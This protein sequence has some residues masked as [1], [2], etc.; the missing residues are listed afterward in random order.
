MNFL[1]FLLLAFLWGIPVL[2]AR[3]ER[4]KA[5]DEQVRELIR[6][7]DAEAF[8]DREKAERALIAIGLAANDLIQDTL[9]NGSPEQQLRAGR[10]AAAFE[11]LMLAGGFHDLSGPVITAENAGR[12]RFGGELDE[13]VRRIV[14]SPDH[15]RVAFVGRDVPVGIRDGM[16]LRNVEDFKTKRGPMSFAFSPRPGVVAYCENGGLPTIHQLE[17]GQ[18]RK[19]ETDGGQHKFSFSPDGS[20]LVTAKYGTTATLWKVEDGSVVARLETGEVEGG[21]FPVFSPDGKQIAV[22]NRN[23]TTSIF[24]AAT[25]KKLR[26]LDVKM[27][28]EI[29]YSP[30]GEKLAACYVDGRLGIW[31]AQGGKLLGRRGK[32]SEGTLHGVVVA[33]QQAC[34]DGRIEGTDHGVGCP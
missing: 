31:D 18:E 2:V 5:T 34:R 26:S 11:K 15:K 28:H 10:V 19:L 24:E 3:G 16:T 21:L 12:L 29:A 32:Q 20:Q 6:Q 33:G 23:S 13:K 1:S 4:G 8:E 22:G 9:E 14:W 30:D 25:G 17:T 27:T 7:L